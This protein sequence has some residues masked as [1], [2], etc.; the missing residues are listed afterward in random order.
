MIFAAAADVGQRVETALDLETARSGLHKGFRG[1]AAAAWGYA[2]ARG[3]PAR[4]R[5][6]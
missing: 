6:L 5:G 3:V 1:S 4:A 2:S